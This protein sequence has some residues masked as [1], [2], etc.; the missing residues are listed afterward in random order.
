MFQ[1]F[2]QSSLTIMYHH[3]LVL[4]F[5]TTW[6]HMPLWHWVSLF[7]Y[8]HYHF[9]LHEGQTKTRLREIVMQTK[10][11][12]LHPNHP[13]QHTTP[14][15]RATAPPLQANQLIVKRMV[16]LGNFH[17]IIVPWIR[18]TRWCLMAR[19]ARRDTRPEEDGGSRSHTG[20]I[21]S[22]SLAHSKHCDHHWCN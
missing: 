3:S 17:L 18:K 9:P 20:G 2:I 13:N 21:P 12:I 5:N 11:I 15:I 16:G 10:C 7:C 19:S 4:F 22:V 8:F 1:I 14:S 6:V